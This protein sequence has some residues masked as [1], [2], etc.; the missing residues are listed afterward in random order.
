MKKYITL[1]IAVFI[2]GVLFSQ[3]TSE[4]QSFDS[5]YFAIDDY[6][7]IRSEPS[8]K[9]KVLGKLFINDEIIVNQEK[10]SKEWFYCYIPKYDC[11]G[12][13][14]STYFKY[15]PFFNEL[16]YGLIQNDKDSISIVES[17]NFQTICLDVLIK[18]YLSG[19][20]EK[21]CLKLIKIAYS[22]GCNYASRDD[23][24]L[25]EAVKLNYF[26]I[27]D[28]LLS[29]PEIKDEINIKKNQFAPPL[30][31]ALWNDNIDVVELLLKNGAEPNY[32]TAY[33]THAFDNI[34]EFIEINRVQENNAKEL[35]EVLIK[36]G[37]NK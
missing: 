14:F 32:E 2:Y 12:Y 31:W 7:N 8:T 6:I 33:S 3:V 16:I 29:I 13:C 23:T 1:I 26:S 17:G 37:Y 35:R 22:S 15:K 36:Y 11:V 10:S 18:N 20:T 21:D 19:I 24:I 5:Y 9:S 34:L 28:Y 27:V 4:K 30:F 25:I